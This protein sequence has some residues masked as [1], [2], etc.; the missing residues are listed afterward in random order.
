MDCRFSG[1]ATKLGGYVSAVVNNLNLKGR[2]RLRFGLSMTEKVRKLWHA[3]CEVIKL[4]RLYI[5]M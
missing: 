3:A 2:K 5:H 1:N 4:T